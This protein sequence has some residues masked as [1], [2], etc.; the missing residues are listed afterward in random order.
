[1]LK[2]KITNIEEEM[3]LNDKEQ[4]IFLDRLKLKKQK[5]TYSYLCKIILNFF[6]LVPFQNI[7]MLTDQRKRPS[8][9]KIKDDILIGIGGLCTVRNPFLYFFLHSLGFNVKFASGSMQEEDCHIC[10]IVKIGTDEYWVDVGNGY[11]YLSPIKLGDNIEINHPFISYRLFEKND[12]WHVQHLRPKEKIWKT[13]YTFKSEGVPYSFFDRM[14]HFHYTVPGWG[15]FLTGI[16]INRWWKD[17]GLIIRD[18]R[19]FS[20]EGE[21]ELNS[22]KEMQFWIEK[23]FLED[24]FTNINI[25]KAWKIWK[26]GDK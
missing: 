15:P 12:I 8:I 4:K 24:F 2:S 26:E 16:R 5:P 20:P 25:K 22:P 17:G 9:R 14:H 6:E 3:S 21:V 7:S 18:T 13:N 10:L 19:A 1:M 23:W 11:P